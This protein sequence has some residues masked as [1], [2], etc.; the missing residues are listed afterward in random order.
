VKDYL[1]E[2]DCSFN[3]GVTGAENA[4]LSW[5]KRS[6]EWGKSFILF[7]PRLTFVKSG[8]K[9]PLLVVLLFPK[10]GNFGGLF[11]NEFLYIHIFS[12]GIYL[13]PV[14]VM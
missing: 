1:V 13:D 3:I 2:K 14:M 6:C 11:V 4:T 5:P 12:L 7:V 9:E 8:L 10:S